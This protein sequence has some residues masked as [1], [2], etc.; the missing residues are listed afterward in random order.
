[1][2]NFTDGVASIHLANGE[3]KIKVEDL[4]VSGKKKYSGGSP[5]TSNLRYFLKINLS[6]TAL[7]R[8]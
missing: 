8:P 7:T 6:L 5:S 2:D 3:R 1:M 4:L